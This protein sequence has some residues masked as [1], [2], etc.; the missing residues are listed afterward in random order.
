MNTTF[1]LIN[2]EKN[3]DSFVLL[4]PIA[5]VFE[6]EI[7]VLKVSGEGEIYTE[8]INE[9]NGTK[10]FYLVVDTRYDEGIKFEGIKNDKS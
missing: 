4:E 5:R 1:E 6:L 10:R 3:W 9:G 7:F 8:I 2:S